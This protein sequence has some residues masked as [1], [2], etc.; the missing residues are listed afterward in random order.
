MRDMTMKQFL[1]YIIR[2]DK[3]NKLFE[4]TVT[5]MIFSCNRKFSKS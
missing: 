3:L 2:K 4:K 5:Q 1:P